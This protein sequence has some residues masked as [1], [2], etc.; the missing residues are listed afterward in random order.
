MK[1]IVTLILFVFTIFLANVNIN[2]AYASSY[3][4]VNYNNHSDN[5]VT[6]NYAIMYNDDGVQM[7]HTQ[8]SGYTKNILIV[9][10]SDIQKMREGRMTDYD[11]A[12]IS[13]TGKIYDFGRYIHIVYEFNGTTFVYLLDKPNNIMSINGRLNNDS[14]YLVSYKVNVLSYQA[15]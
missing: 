2:Y 6:T 7:I 8:G 10:E 14:E 1:K 5:L 12:R 4:Y 13:Y 11:L 9:D 3:P 15:V